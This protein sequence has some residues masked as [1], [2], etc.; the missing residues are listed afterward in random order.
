MKKSL[1]TLSYKEAEDL[2]YKTKWKTSCCSQGR[3]CWCRLIVPVK[4]I[5]FIEHGGGEMYIA[6]SGEIDKRAAEYIVKLHNDK[7]ELA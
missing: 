5:K 6:G 2:L 3:S 4:K 7:L 1:M